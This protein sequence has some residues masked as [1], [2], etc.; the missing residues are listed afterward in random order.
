MGLIQGQGN[1]DIIGKMCVFQATISLWLKGWGAMGGFG[2]YRCV[3]D[4]LMFAVKDVP[5]TACGA[6]SWVLSTL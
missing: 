2:L 5:D 6:G 3:L 1:L 4:S